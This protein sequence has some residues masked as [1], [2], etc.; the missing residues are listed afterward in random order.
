MTPARQALADLLDTIREELTWVEEDQNGEAHEV[1]PYGAT[2]VEHL[3]SPSTGP[4]S[5][6]WATSW[7]SSSGPSAPERPPPEPPSIPT[8]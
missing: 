2:Y 6:P 4:C 7:P 5:L 1:T 3:T 8:P